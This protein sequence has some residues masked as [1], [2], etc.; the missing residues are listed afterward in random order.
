MVRTLFLH[1]MTRPPPFPDTS[2]Q[3]CPS[4]LHPGLHYG[5]YRVTA[6][7]LQYPLFPPINRVKPW[8]GWSATGSLPDLNSRRPD[9]EYRRPYRHRRYYYRMKD[10]PF[11]RG[12]WSW[13]W[14]ALCDRFSW[15]SAFVE[16]HATHERDRNHDP[17]V[18]RGRTVP[19]PSSWIHA[20]PPEFPPV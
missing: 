18:R 8:F 4:R 20:R 5:R 1:P 10:S 15:P 19:A 17:A 16:L 2:L 6:T 14:K 7:I 9:P 3:V 11:E 12:P 13:R